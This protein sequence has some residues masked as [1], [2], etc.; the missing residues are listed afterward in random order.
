MKKFLII[1]VFI[2]AV[3]SLNAQSGLTV[4]KQV[5]PAV[6]VKGTGTGTTTFPIILGEY[7]VSIQMIPATSG[8]GTSLSFSHIAYLSDSYT[9]N[10]WS[11]VTAADTVT[12]A[13]DSD[14]IIY[15]TDMKPVRVKVIYT[16]LSSDTI[17]VTPYCVYK[18]HADEAYPARSGATTIN[19]A[20]AL[21]AITLNGAVADTVTFP[22]IQGEYDASLQLIPALTGSGDSLH[23]SYVLYQSDSD[24]AN[25]WTAIT[26]SATVSSTTD[27]DAL[28]AIT[29][30]KGLR[31]RAICLGLST[32]TCTVTPYYTYKKHAQE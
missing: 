17:T 28:V 22:P 6:T 3:L 18:M 9:A 24:D 15:W 13:T 14:G 4:I 1:L 21:A 30:F 12:T 16:G 27:G 20:P 5:M 31:M 8:A 11:A 23:F 25:A 29:D 10:A 32:D 19:N 2:V 7:D 26:S